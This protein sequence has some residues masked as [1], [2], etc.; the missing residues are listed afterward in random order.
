MMVDLTAMGRLG[1]PDDIAALVCFLVSG[2]AGWVTAETIS[3]N[4]GVKP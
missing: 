2:D 3:A 1:K 4:G